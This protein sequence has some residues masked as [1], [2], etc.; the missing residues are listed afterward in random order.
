MLLT[1]LT[2]CQTGAAPGGAGRTAAE[3]QAIQAEANDWF[4]AIAAK[5]LD[6][7]LSFYSADAEYMSAGR[8]AVSTAEERRRLW[9]EDYASPGFASDET[10]SRI[11]VAASGDLAYQRGTYV[12][13]AQDAL[14]KR[15]K[16]TGKFVVVW[17][18]QGDGKW[19][20]IIDIDNADQ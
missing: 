11:E 9:M 8:P 12:L 16:S 14:G 20:A 15:T 10:T 17:K 2:A 3:T 18:K 4:K 6:K 7:T 13:S 19:K 5:D 1:G